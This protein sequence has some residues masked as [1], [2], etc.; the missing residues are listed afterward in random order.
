MFV[1]RQRQMEYDRGMRPVSDNHVPLPSYVELLFPT[2]QALATLGGQSKIAELEDKVIEILKI[3]GAQLAVEFQDDSS[4]K[5]SKVRDRL[6]WARSYLHKLEAAEPAS[7]GVWCLTEAG[8]RY[9]NLADGE[10]ELLHREHELRV[11]QSA[12]LFL[13]QAVELAQSPEPMRMTVRRLLGEWGVSRRGSAVVSRISR[14]LSSAGLM[15][16]P[17][18]DTIGL[19]VEVELRKSQTR[20]MNTPELQEALEPSSHVVTIGTLAS[21]GSG[22]VF[23]APDEP[24]IC[25]QSLMESNDYSQLAIMSGER[26]LKGAVSWESIARATLYHEPPETAGAAIISDPVIVYDDEPL[27][28]HTGTIANAGFVFVRDRANRV[29]GIVTAADLSHQFASMA[30][31][32]LLIGE[33]EGWL[34][35]LVD[36]SISPDELVEFVDP[37][38]PM[39]E[40][41][42]SESLTFGEYLR[43]FQTPEVWEK[44]RLSADRKIFCD[45]L[46]DVRR[47]RNS[48]MHFSPDP[49]A[50]AD[51]TK[52]ESLL[53]WLRKLAQATRK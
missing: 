15:T 20:S 26:S 49:V 5:G 23:V 29:T 37:A 41:G 8:E 45:R 44:M 39:R 47:I 13:K 30:N 12:D 51:L 9:L 35:S 32:F 3:S 43:L 1:Q 52:I 50:E 16:E 19:D 22:V 40:L 25:V 11:G 27:L 7:H 6:G 34:R 36:A 42:A 2:L 10:E 14:D 21:A 18:F 4:K 33:I 46:D 17:T 28:G 48:I 24:I 53:Q 31:P 38:D